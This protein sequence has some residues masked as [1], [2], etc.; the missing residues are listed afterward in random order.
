MP[1]VLTQKS[2]FLPLNDITISTIRSVKIRAE[3]NNAKPK[4]TTSSTKF[5]KNIFNSL[6][7]KCLAFKISQ[8]VA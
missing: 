8:K 2:I 7:S 4:D 3:R 5:S 6:E 1:E